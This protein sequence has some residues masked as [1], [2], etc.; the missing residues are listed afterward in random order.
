MNKKSLEKELKRFK[1]YLKE[2]SKEANNHT[3]DEK[4]IISYTLE[5]MIMT[6][7]NLIKTGAYDQSEDTTKKLFDL[8]DEARNTAIHYGYFNDLNNIFPHA[9][10]IASN[11][12]DDFNSNFA[13]LLPGFNLIE[14]KPYYQL[15]QTDKTSIKEKLSLDG[16]F[17]FKSLHTK[18]ELYIK[19]EDLIII[20]NQFNHISSYLVKDSN[21]ENIFYKKSPNDETIKISFHS[22]LES[23]LLKQFKIVEKGKKL[24]TSLKKILD[25]LKEDSYKN[26]VISYKYNEKTI[27]V[28]AH[29]VLKDFINNRTLDDKILNGYFSIKDY[30]EVHELSPINVISLPIKDMSKSATLS[31]IF[32]IEFYIKRY[33]LY[34]ELKQ[35]THENDLEIST[36]AKQA[37]LINLFETGA[38]SLS[39]KFLMSDRSKQ[40][41][42]LFY[43]YK[44]ARNELAHCAITNRVK[45]EALIRNLELY[46]DIFYTILDE[47]YNSYYKEKNRNPYA[48]LPSISAWDST[49]DIINNKTTKFAKLNHYGIC[50]IKNGKKYLKIKVNNFHTYLDV[51]GSFLSLDYNTLTSTSCIVSLDRA[52]IVEIDNNTNEITPAHISIKDFPIIDVDYNLQTLIQAHDHFKTFPQYNKKK[53]MNKC[54]CAITYLD[55]DGNPTYTEGL[56]NVIYRRFSKKF[57]HLNYLKPLIYYCHKI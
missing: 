40:F 49:R 5:G 27:N 14:D 43:D 24:N 46:S 21:Q 2:I 15:F 53:D 30:D 31:D 52:K 23:Q 57:F 39:D 6:I 36:Y 33:A 25:S 10:Q 29:N 47:T 48:K 56:K 12:P 55:K 16:F 7:H 32:F 19:K 13:T 51:D 22:L 18:E 34:Q 17:V 50:K 11:I 9:K 41:A 1:H 42:K 3:V 8:V 35:S 37:L 38:A 54:F 28:T 44:R 4:K 26:I 45:K 20:E